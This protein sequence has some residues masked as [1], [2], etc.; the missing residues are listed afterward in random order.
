[1][2]TT[3]V[4]VDDVLGV[5][6]AEAA[7]DI[8]RDGDREVHRD[9]HPGLVQH[10]VQACRAELGDD[11]ERAVGRAV[12]AEELKHVRVPQRLQARTVLLSCKGMC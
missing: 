12:P 5:Q 7:R 3:Y 9:G 11:R 2:N 1:V 6:V 10:A 4:A 8:L